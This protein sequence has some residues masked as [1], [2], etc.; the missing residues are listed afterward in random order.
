M[1]HSIEGQGAKAGGRPTP[2]LLGGR[3]GL[4]YLLW[5]LLVTVGLCLGLWQ[6]ER[7][8]DKRRYLARLDAAP[9]LESPSEMP[10]EGARLTLRGEYLAQETLFLDNRTHE[11]QLGVAV[12]TPLRDEAGRLWLVQRGFLPTGPSRETPTAATPAGEVRVH[13]RWQAAGDGPPLFGPNREGQRLQRIDLAE[14]DL[15]GG[16]AHPGWLHL[17]EGPGRLAPWWQP[18]VVPPGRHVGYAVQWWGLALA[19][20]AVMLIGGRRLASE[21]RAGRDAP[22]SDN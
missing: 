7:A 8:D 22:G 4:W 15:P 6:W 16:F 9:T 20:L 12:L 2:R 21:R 19:A 13:G 18:S 17:E 14:W 3:L 1:G 11:G 10:P 5:S